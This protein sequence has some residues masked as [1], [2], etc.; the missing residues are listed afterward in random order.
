MGSKLVG[1]SVRTD[2]ADAAALKV[3][4]DDWQSAGLPR[5][6]ALFKSLA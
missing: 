3:A 5:A 2:P 4:D 1:A 6:T